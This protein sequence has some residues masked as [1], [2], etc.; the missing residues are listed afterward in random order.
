MRRLRR[1]F[2]EIA[3]NTPPRHVLDKS[4]LVAFQDKTRQSPGRVGA[5][6]DVDPVRPNVRLQDGGVP[7]HYHFAKVVLA[8]EKILSYPQEVVL[9]LFG[10]ANSRSYSC[11]YKEEIAANEILLQV[12]QELAVAGRK[13]PVKFRGEFSVILRIG[14]D[15]RR[16]PI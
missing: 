12:A 3:R 9:G 2:E 5:R 16:K 15:F 6:I 4:D 10:E 13:N 1:F 7:M 14:F 8:K 11:M